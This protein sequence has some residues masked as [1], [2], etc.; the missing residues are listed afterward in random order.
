MGNQNDCV[1]PWPSRKSISQLSREIFVRDKK[2]LVE[3]LVRAN[4]DEQASLRANLAN[5]GEYLLPELRQRY[6]RG[7]QT[8]E[9]SHAI[10]EF[11]RFDQKLI[12]DFICDAE[13][14]GILHRVAKC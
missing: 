14:N 13:P 5:L 10:C 8:V 2:A 9:T 7:E 4:F 11:A 6:R 12:S 1:Q 3:G